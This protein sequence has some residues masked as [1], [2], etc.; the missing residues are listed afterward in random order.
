M[1]SPGLAALSVDAVNRGPSLIALYLTLSIIAFVF[2]VLRLWV[3]I[4][5]YRLG[6]DDYCALVAAVLLALE[7]FFTGVC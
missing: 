1:S 6:L 7:P 2:T 3:R 5:R 4:T